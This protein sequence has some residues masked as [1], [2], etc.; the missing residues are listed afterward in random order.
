[1]RGLWQAGLRLAGLGLAAGLMALPTAAI[2]Q[3]TAQANAQASVQDGAPACTITTR[4]TPLVNQALSAT[5]FNFAG[6][7]Q[8]CETLRAARM[9]VSFVEGAGTV[10][11][12]GYGVVVARVYDLATRTQGNINA[13]VS[14]MDERADD[15]GRDRALM[16]SIDQAMTAIAQ[17]PQDHIAAVHQEQARLRAVFATPPAP[18][19]AA[20]PGDCRISYRGDDELDAFITRWNGLPG[21]GMDDLCRQLADANAGISFVHALGA[22]SGRSYGWVALTLYDRAS[23]IDGDE[24]RVTIATDYDVS[25][26]NSEDSLWQAMHDGLAS[27]KGEAPH[28]LDTVARQ[29]A[30]NREL[31]SR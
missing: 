11:D 18:P 30:R 20:Q 10:A 28:I 12:R 6:Y 23:G 17:R 13:A 3:D 31:Y 27:L 29:V 14:G 22:V 16:V 19:A 7:Q 9:G 26:Q 24:W 1:M 5:Q 15:A 4:A 8:L 2:A 21:D 25:Q